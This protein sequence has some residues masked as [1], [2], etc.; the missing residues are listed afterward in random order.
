LENALRRS[1]TD[2]PVRRRS[3]RATAKQ[4]DPEAI[5]GEDGDNSQQFKGTPFEFFFRGH[6]RDVAVRAQGSSS[7]ATV[8]SHDL[9]VVD[10]ADTI[11]SP[12]GRTEYKD[13]KLVAAMTATDIAVIK[14]DAKDL[15]AAKS[16][17][18]EVKVANGPSRMARR[19]NSTTASLSVRQRQGRPPMGE[20]GIVATIYYIQTDAAIKSGNSGGPLCDIEGRVIGINT[21][22]R[23]LNPAS[24][25]PSRSNVAMDSAARSSS[26]RQSHASLD[27]H[28]H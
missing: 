13:A 28:R 15:T 16:P 20:P 21:L 2:E 17:H 27:R 9:H 12:Q 26:G 5:D 3:S 4:R 1:P 22:I 19:T 25:L 18:D 7:V 10:G 23:G 8:Y 6:P 11:T 24:A 14:V